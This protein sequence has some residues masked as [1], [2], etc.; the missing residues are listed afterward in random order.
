MTQRPDVVVPASLPPALRQVLTAVY[1][2]LR[3]LEADIATLQTRLGSVNYRSTSTTTVGGGSSSTSSALSVVT[4][5]TDTTLTGRA[6]YLCDETG[7]AFTVTMPTA[8][9]KGGQ[10]WYFLKIGGTANTVTLAAAGGETIQGAA[11]LAMSEP[12]MSITLFSDDTQWW[13]I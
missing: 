10:F 8:V 2:R 4:L 3:M 9:G 12:E 7:G 6:I 11:D 1:Q 5:T 13:V